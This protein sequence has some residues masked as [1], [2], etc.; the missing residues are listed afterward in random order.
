MSFLAVPVVITAADYRTAN[1]SFKFDWSSSMTTFVHRRFWD[2]GFLFDESHWRVFRL[3]RYANPPHRDKYL[4]IAVEQISNEML[5]K[6][7]KTIQA[8]DSNEAPE[9]NT[10][11][12][13]DH[14]AT[15]FQKHQFD[16]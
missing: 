1:I 12:P 7:N 2:S 11:D 5:P 14:H 16:N 6:S 13:S 9:A 10:I 8:V 3:L 15:I 4:N